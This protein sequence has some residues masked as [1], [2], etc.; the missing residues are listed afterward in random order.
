MLNEWIIL[1][2][3]ELIQKVSALCT[4][5]KTGTLFM[6]IHDSHAAGL[7]I[8]QGEISYCFFDHW[9]NNEALQQIKNIMLAK[10][11]F[12]EKVLFSFIDYSAQ[13][14]TVAI[15]NELGYQYEPPVSENI[16]EKS[17]KIYRGNVVYDDVIVEKTVDAGDD[18]EVKKA[19]RIYRGQVF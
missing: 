17:V 5:Q 11:H 7:V 8:K 19:K 3:T 14:S 18:N 16:A 2:K 13:L 9:K 15:F 12:A 4:Q 6:S 1:N 10:C